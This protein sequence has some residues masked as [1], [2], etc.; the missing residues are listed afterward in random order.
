MEQ[1]E[2][3]HLYNVWSVYLH[4]ENP[5]K[6]KKNGAGEGARTLDLQSHNLAF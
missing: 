4:L 2:L 3:G 6:Q 5:Q 1:T